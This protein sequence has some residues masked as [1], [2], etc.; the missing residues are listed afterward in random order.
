MAP[1]QDQE[2]LHTLA[3]HPL[4]KSGTHLDKLRHLRASKCI[5]KCINS[6]YPLASGGLE[7]CELVNLERGV[8]TYRAERYI[9]LGGPKRDI[10]RKPL[11]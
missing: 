9:Y 6:I 5:P 4:G 8:R 11:L 3:A 1:S 10:Y 7:G 2:Q